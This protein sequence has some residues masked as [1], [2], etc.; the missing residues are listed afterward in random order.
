MTTD[1]FW[2]HAYEH[3]NKP[4][5]TKVAHAFVPNDYFLSTHVKNK[6]RSRRFSSPRF[7]DTIFLV[8]KMHFGLL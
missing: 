3:E 8:A 6:L 5:P 1:E 7:G 4:Y 2:I